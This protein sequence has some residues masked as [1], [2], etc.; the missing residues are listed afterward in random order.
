MARV[1]A[2]AAV[3]AAVAGLQE[4][5]VIVGEIKKLV[6]LAGVELNETPEIVCKKS[7]SAAASCREKYILLA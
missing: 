1:A 6:I 2:V 7:G 4:N 5:W 3:I